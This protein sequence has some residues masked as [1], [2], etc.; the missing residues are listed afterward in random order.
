VLGST[1]DLL[2]LF[3]I[4]V[5]GW[6]AYRDIRTRRVPNRAWLPLAVLALAL[7]AWDGYH[8]YVGDDR[9][10]F[11]QV[12]ISVGFIIPL[13]TAFWYMGSFGGADAKAFYVVALLFPAAPV[14]YL[15]TVALP[16]RLDTVTVLS[17]T[18]LS[19]TVLVGALYPLGVALSNLFRG[20]FGLP[21]LIGRPIGWQAVEEEYGMLLETPDGFTRRGVDLDA[22]RMYLRWRD[23][24][25]AQLRDDPDWFRNP[26][27]LPD[28]PGDV[29]DGNVVVDGGGESPTEGRALG[30]ASGETGSNEGRAERGPQNGERG[31]ER[32][33]SNEN[34][35]R[36]FSNTAN[37]EERPVSN[38]GGQRDPPADAGEADDPWGAAAFLD[39]I[40]GGA[41]GTT[42]EGLR[43]GLDVLV[44]EKEVWISPGIP[45]IV[46][47]F[48][49]IVLSLV[50]GD[51]LVALLSLFG[52]GA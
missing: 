11:L 38:E 24:T 30:N 39:D 41:Y 25:L 21:M 18:I 22:L 6:A 35:Q 42:P 12:A 13:A 31:V 29:G 26:A 27:S 1:A 47:M 16:L 19:N 4:P 28:N 40:E 9:L 43:E 10:F 5:F 44:A 17:L 49:G 32:P 20:R 14:Y 23:C 37:G 7:L 50:Y 51:V 46:P 15:P 8:A 36:E 2:R 33:V 52:I 45:F 34:D 48:F 3:A